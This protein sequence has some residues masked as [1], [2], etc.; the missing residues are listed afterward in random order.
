MLNIIS[1]GYLN[2]LRLFYVNKKSFHL[3]EIAKK[4]KLNE[5]SA[6]RFLS[7]LE[8]DNI[9]LSEKKGNMKFFSIKDNKKTYSI[10]TFFDI[11]R[12]E[13]LP[14]IRRVA[15]E[16]YLNNLL[17]QP[18]FVI[19]FGSTA[20]DTFRDESDIDILIVT[21]ERINAKKAENEANVQSTLKISTFQIDYKKFIKE[22]KLKNDMVI[23]SALETGYPLINHIKYYEEI[24]NAKI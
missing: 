6:Y 8:K 11:E 5:N 15:I 9:L 17:K 23:Q 14:S 21:N 13:K 24:R 2:I 18:I 12:Y 1:K 20:K 4:T 7:K 10:I 19:L 22:L 16:T 3:R